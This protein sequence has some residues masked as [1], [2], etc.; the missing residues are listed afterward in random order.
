M[1]SMR[2]IAY[3]TFPSKTDLPNVLIG[4]R[5]LLKPNGLFYLGVY[6]GYD[7]EGIW[8]E[9]RQEPK[10]FF[11]FFTNDQ[12]QQVVQG[13]F[14]LIYFRAILLEEKTNFHF[15]SMVVRRPPN[16]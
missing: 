4:I 9:D 6:G 15:Q 13:F 2:S 7:F 14:D 10:R 12:I 1:Q 16:V 11:S 8:A 3:C 5:Y